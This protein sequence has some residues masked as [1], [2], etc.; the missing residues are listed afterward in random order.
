MNN[1]VFKEIDINDKEQVFSL[2]AT[3]LGDLDRKDFFIPYSDEEKAKFFDKSYAYHYGAFENDK[4]VA[5]NGIYIEDSSIEDYYNILNIDKSE[6]ICE[7]GGFLTLKEY[8]GKGIMT[9]LSE[10]QLELAKELNIDYM[11][12]TA[13]PEN[14]AS[15]NILEKIGLDLFDTIIT[16]SGYLR[17]VYYKKLKEE[18]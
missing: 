10:K 3:V 8:T 2:I 18:E 16:S 4:L 17:N 12:A 6:S 11:V 7:L 5:I 9:K 15:C 13:H 1:L 14:K